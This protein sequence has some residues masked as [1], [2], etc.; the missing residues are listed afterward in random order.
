MGSNHNPFMK[1]RFCKGGVGQRTLLGSWFQSFL[2]VVFTQKLYDL[3]YF[4]IC[5]F[6]HLILACL[7]LWPH[8]LYSTQFQFQSKQFFL[9]QGFVWE[10]RFILI[11]LSLMV[12]RTIRIGSNAIHCT[13]LQTE[14]CKNLS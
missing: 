10:D 7:V 4:D 1:K 3:V 11:M 9:V 8:C 14:Y 5:F 6:P 12:S 2:S 13:H